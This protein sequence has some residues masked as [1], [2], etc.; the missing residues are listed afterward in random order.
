MTTP[1]VGTAGARG[2]VVAGRI[3]VPLV[4]VAAW[5][6]AAAVTP[7][8][9]PVAESVRAVA[10]AWADGTLR[11][12]VLDTLQAVV[13]GF[14]LSAAAGIPFGVWAARGGYTYQVVEPLFA[15]TAAVPRIVLLPVFLSLFGITV[16]A[17]IAMAVSAAIVPIVLT[18]MAGTRTVNPT[19]VKLGRSLAMSRWALLRRV[20][21]PAA[22]PVIMSGLRIG[23]S[24]A[25]LAVILSEFVAAT[26]GIGLRIQAA[27]SLQQ[28]PLMY[29][30]VVLVVLV[31][32][33]GNLAI[34]LVERR[35]AR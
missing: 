25:L 9:A 22:L 31:G 32:L 33:A 2:L 5:A 28:L 10:A 29:G 8:I 21:V 11:P 23:F 4:L 15:G 19:L 20:I 27:Y 35:A 18:S 16:D 17:K 30:L 7:E 3:A 24:L 13:A 34:W 14:A 26:R 1:T 6:A 12:D